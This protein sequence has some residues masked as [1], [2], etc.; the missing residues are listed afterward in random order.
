MTPLITTAGVGG[1]LYSSNLCRAL[2]GR[3]CGWRLRITEY[4]MLEG[5]FKDHHIQPM[6]LQS[7][8]QNLKPMCESVIWTLLELWQLGAITTALGSLCHAHHLLVKN[9]FLTSSLTLPWH[10][11]MPFPRALSLSAESRAQSCPSAPC[12]ELQPPWGLPSAPL[13]CAEHTGTSSHHHT[14]AGH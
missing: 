1:R 3:N 2:V 6:A 8:T 13:L 7:T 14:L 5:T 9:F 10:S 4:P 11:S 12:E